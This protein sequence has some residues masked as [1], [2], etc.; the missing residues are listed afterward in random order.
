M[1]HYDVFNGDADGIC[2]L[3]QLRLN[4][5]R[6]ARLVTGTKRENALLHRVRAAPGDEVTA[7][8]IALPGNV[9]ALRGLLERGVRVRYIDHH[10]PGEVPAH[11]LLE[12]VIDTSPEVCTSILV[13][14]LL[15]GRHRAWAVV[16]AFGDNLPGPAAKL[17]A[18]LGRDDATTALWRELGECL[19]YNAYGMTEDDLVYRPAD[20]YRALAGHADPS[21]FVDAQPHFARLRTARAQDLAQARGCTPVA[22]GTQA[23]LHRLPDA[24]W[25]RRVSGSYANIVFNDDPGRA[26]VVAV[27]RG[28]AE[29][30]PDGDGEILQLSLRMPAGSPVA[31]HE[32]CKRF[33][34]GGRK[35]AAGIDRLAEAD[36]P[37]FGQA[38]EQAF[39]ALG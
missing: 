21:R 5:P 2:A 33:G 37:R 18:G 39:R 32:I 20:L 25:A 27:P 36:L 30:G 34:G 16:A 26:Q 14:R 17:A 7:L 9:V 31:A 8:D 35:G 10:E 28:P 3:H 4:T 11:P 24:A 19:N 13:D 12:A 15:E 38:L 29:R 23:R 6:D 1:N 22:L